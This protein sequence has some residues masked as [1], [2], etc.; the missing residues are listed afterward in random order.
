MNKKVYIVLIVL[1]SVIVAGGGYFV[2]K[3][4]LTTLDG[5]IIDE[6]CFEKK[7]PD[8]E[9]V[10]CLQME[11]CES[12]GYGIGIK[13]DGQKIF[14]KFDA[15]GHEKAKKFIEENKDKEKLGEVIVTGKEEGD[16]FEVKSIKF[17]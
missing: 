11:A 8:E 9:T 13:N 4:S 7:E 16:V 6:H 14:H 1:L 15:N 17:K 2:Y 3:S 12:S 5:Y 10:M